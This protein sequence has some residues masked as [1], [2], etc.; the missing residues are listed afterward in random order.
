[1][2][3]VMLQKIPGFLLQKTVFLILHTQMEIILYVKNSL[4]LATMTR[5]AS[6]P[7][8]VIAIYK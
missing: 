4:L 1:M 8:A 5:G 7:I 2:A 6:N 3:A